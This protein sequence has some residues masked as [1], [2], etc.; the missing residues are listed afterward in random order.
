MEKNL[1]TFVADKNGKLSKI[2][3]QKTEDLSYSMFCKL[4]R[5]K[6][7]KVNNKRVGEDIIIAEGD[8]VNIYYTPEKKEKYT[9][10]YIDEN[11]IVIDKKSG[12]SSES[13]FD[14]LKENFSEVYFIHRLDRNTAGIMILART[15]VA[16]KELI[17]GFKN[18]TFDKTY[19]AEVKGRPP[20]KS[21]IITAY[22]FKDEKKSQVTI[23]DKKVK[24]SVLIKTGYEAIKE[25]ID[26]TILR[27][28]LY[29][30]KTHQIRA[31]LAYVGCPIVGDGKYGDNDF[32]KKQG[33]KS[34]K[35]K[36]VS[37]ELHFNDSDNLSYL[38][39][40]TFRLEE[41]I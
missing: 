20:K 35:L 23:T 17:N 30:G 2:V 19:I 5:K 18:R 29:T 22:L 7:I 10:V 33:A 27:V 31:H 13:I 24:G 32:N 28:K 8:E 11:I 25:K 26:T 1:I 9:T 21:D 38:N 39:N 3:M 15:K 6:D 16:E 12:Y 14:D 40:K 4:L 34:Q 41:E 36:A 37:L